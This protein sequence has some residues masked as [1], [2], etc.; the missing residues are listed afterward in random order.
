MRRPKMKILQINN[1]HYIRGGSDKIYMETSRLLQEKGHTVI[2]FSVRDEAVA[3]A[4]CRD[5]FISPHEYFKGNFLK[6]I[7]N[8]LFINKT[9]KDQNCGK[10]T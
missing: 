8:K 2:N 6:N 10:K 3:D 5:Y 4:N 7:Y 1:Y 9:K